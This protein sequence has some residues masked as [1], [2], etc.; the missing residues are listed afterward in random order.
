MMSAT[1]FVSHGGSHRWHHLSRENTQAYISTLN[2]CECMGMHYGMF[3]CV[4]TLRSAAS[5]RMVRLLCVFY[6]LSEAPEAESWF[7]L[8]VFILDSEPYVSI[9]NRTDVHTQA[10]HIVKNANEQVGL[11]FSACSS[12][13]HLGNKEQ[14]PISEPFKHILWSLG[15]LCLGCLRCLSPS[16]SLLLLHPPSHCPCLF[17]SFFPSLCLFSL[18]TPHRPW[19]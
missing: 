10:E 9:L 3:V 8:C 17:W 11:T 14:W 19:V 15:W 6:F 12:C 2:V 7:S 13:F 16:P 18:F 5:V 4:C 1:R